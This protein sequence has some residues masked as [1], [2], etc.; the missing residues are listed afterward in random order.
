M[1]TIAATLLLAVAAAAAF[2][3]RFAGAGLQ[4]PVAPTVVERVVYVQPPA[5]ELYWD[6]LTLKDDTPTLLLSVPVGRRFV[7]TDLWLLPMERETAGV[8]PLDRVWL[9]NRR[10]G[11]NYIVFDALAKDLDLPLRWNTGVAFQEGTELWTNWDFNPGERRLRR[12]HYTG[13]WEDLPE[14]EGAPA[15]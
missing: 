3:S 4:E 6:T 11:H 5:P 8:H 9:E 15:R 2:L 1:K 10:D 13:Y 14:P 7:L 12:I